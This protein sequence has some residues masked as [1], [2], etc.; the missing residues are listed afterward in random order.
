MKKLF[1]LIGILLAAGLAVHAYLSYRSYNV[2]L[3]TIDT[4]RADFLSCY[5][6]DITRTRNI[7]LIAKKG[8]L[9]K[10]A[11]SLIPITLASHTSI[12]TSRMPHEIDLFTNGQVFN[13]K[14]VPMV[15]DFLKKKGYQSA[16]FISLGVLKA[17]YGLASGF[18]FYQDNFDHTNGRYYKVA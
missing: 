14:D 3:I 11:Y 16:A 5:N 1:I 12:L 2:I 7:D 9:F 15:T 6:P 10:N 13:H 17:E 8:V 18:D 4:L